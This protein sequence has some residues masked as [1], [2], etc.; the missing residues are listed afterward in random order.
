MLTPQF[1]NIGSSGSM[2]LDLITPT[3]DDTSDNVA[4]QTLNAAG[5]TVDTYTWNDYMYAAPCWVNDDFEQVSG[6]VFAAGAG[7]WTY[8]SAVGQGIQTAGVVGTEDVV[9]QLKPGATA[10]GNPFPT[11]LTLDEI[12]PEG[13]DTSDNVA[14]QTLNAAGQ[15]VD[16]Y[17]WNDYMYDNPCWVNDDFEQVSGVKFAA[18]TGLWV[19]GSSTAQYLRF[20]APEL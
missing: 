4:I 20:P 9:V 8:G 18:G 16:T 13:G 7:L 6:V 17:T 19:Y 1:L 5:Q 15:T 12:V 14:I 10:T 3:G 11:T 2:P